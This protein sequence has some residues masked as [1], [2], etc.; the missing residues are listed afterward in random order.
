MQPLRFSFEHRRN[1]TEEFLSPGQLAVAKLRARERRHGVNDQQP[2]A[3]V[4]E[5]LLEPVETLE[6]LGEGGR[7]EYEDAGCESSE[8]L[9]SG[10][11][12]GSV[13]VDGWELGPGDLG[14][15][16]GAELLLGVDEDDAGAE[17]AGGGRGGGGDGEGE[18]QLGLARA[19]GAHELADG[20]RGHPSAQRVVER[21]EVRAHEGGTAG[22]GGGAGGGAHL[23]RGARNVRGVGGGRFGGARR[24][25]RA[26]GGGLGAHV[27]RHRRHHTLRRGQRDVKHLHEVEG[28]TRQ[29]VLRGAEVVAL[30]ARQ[31]VHV[32]TSHAG[33]R[34]LRRHRADAGGPRGS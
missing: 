15:S 18:A 20:A 8:R 10:L 14:E 3:V 34:T 25:E 28:R 31:D 30:Q 11:V 9:A 2:H 23:V 21:G 29:D 4:D 12:A 26:R 24:E 19:G 16:R 32:Q 17:P 33:E 27:A 13:A 1:L 6:N 7:G 22:G 5:R